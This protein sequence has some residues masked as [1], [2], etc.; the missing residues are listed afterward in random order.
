LGASR[1]LGR[2][3]SQ[4]A[5]QRLGQILGLLVIPIV[6]LWSM[7]FYN[8]KAEIDKLSREISGA[9]I[10]QVVFDSSLDPNVLPSLETTIGLHGRRPIIS[11]QRGVDSESPTQL[12]Q[13]QFYLQDVYRASGLSVDGNPHSN[14]LAETML[15]L[16]PTFNQKIEL[17]VQKIASLV[18]RQNSN[19]EDIKFLL[20]VTGETAS[21]AARIAE[22][23]LQ[24]DQ[25]IVNE[26]KNLIANITSM[27]SAI[28]KAGVEFSKPTVNAAVR[29]AHFQQLQ[30][31]HADYK[32]YDNVALQS[33]MSEKLVS[34]LK[35]RRSGLWR[36]LL[37]STVAGLTSAVAGIGLAVLMM[38]STLVQLDDVELAHREAQIAKIDA[39]QIA[40]R[41]STINTDISR[42][43]QE[44]ATNVKTLK[45]AQDELIKKGQFDQLG[46][47]IATIAHEIRNPLGAIRTSVFTLDRK[48]SKVGFEAGDLIER[49]NN[50]VN[51]CDAIISQL[52]DFAKVK[53]SN[54]V[55]SKLDD[56]LSKTV[57]DEA[58]RLP[59]NVFIE[60]SLG[61]GDRLVSFDPVQLQRAVVNLLNNACEALQQLN[62]QSGTAQQQNHIWVTTLMNGE[63][64][65]IRIADNG[66]G[67]ATEYLNKI[68]EP[69][70]TTKSFG[71]GLG[72]PVV[73]QIV[74]S[75][76]GHLDIVS[77]IGKG[78]TMTINLPIQQDRRA[79]NAA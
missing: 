68:R 42:L 71:S 3:A 8:A 15:V 45:A 76:G 60:C 36:N 10:A 19:D 26:T 70:F 6:V 57:R 7:Y 9:G 40:L 31:S 27:S 69:L 44:L 2:T 49:I 5:V 53:P 48:L 65:A 58:R 28:E 17:L 37:L 67:I 46:Q 32:K 24:Q 64:A 54:K 47:L 51:R 30:N 22:N 43:N 77:D 18:Q 16:L 59:T 50:S 39:E 29:L 61:L 56:W 38:R 4:T 20:L 74:K 21:L 25:S 66:P 52:H 41:F 75:Q 73:E 13:Q 34:D 79:S 78:A 12:E 72:I 11:Q 55:V 63:F 62:G 35:S 1:A 33:R 23:M 14:A